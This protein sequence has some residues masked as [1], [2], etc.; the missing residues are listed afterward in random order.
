MTTPRNALRPL[1][2]RLGAGRPAR[3]RAFNGSSAPSAKATRGIPQGPTTAAI[4][5]TRNNN[6]RSNHATAGKQERKGNH[7]ALL[8]SLILTP[9][10]ILITLS[11]GVTTASAN[12]TRKFE[13]QITSVA[14]PGGVATDSANDLWVGD[15]APAF[16]V[17]EFE[18]ASA[19]NKPV[20]LAKPFTVGVDP[21]SIAIESATT[22]NGDVYV[23]NPESVG[24]E[25]FT[26]NGE[27]V[28]SWSGFEYASV[29]V[30]NS[31]EGDIA[32]PSHCV[33]AA[34]F[35]YATDRTS[36]EKLSSTGKEEAFSGSA[37]YIAAG[38]ITGRPAGLGCGEQFVLGLAE[39][40]GVA[41]DGDGDIF[42]AVPQCAEV[43][44]YLASG[45]Y[46][47]AFDLAGP[48]VQRV[49]ADGDI[50]KPEAVAVDPASNHLLVSV[51]AEAGAC[52]AIDEFD[53]ET[54][55]FVT[56]IAETGKSGVILHPDAIASDAQGDLYLTDV[57]RHAVDVWGPGGYFP[58]V[59]VGA[60][61]ERTATSA[62]LNGSVN[63][64]QSGNPTPAP[65][66]A[67]SFEYVTEAVFVKEGFAHAARATCEPAEI[68]AGLDEPHP[69][70]AT[71]EHL[72]AGTTYYYRLSATTEP[73][74]NGGT[75]DS[76]ALAFTAPGKPRVESS[77][78]ENISSTFAELHAQIDPLGAGTSYF[79]EYGP[80]T[81]YGHDAPL[82]TEA[83]PD[84][85]SIGSGGPTGSASD[86]VVQ[87]IGGLTPGTAY[88]FRVVATNEC[89]AGKQCVT[90][91]ADQT[92]ATLPR[93]T[94]GLPDN[95]SYELVTPADKEGGSDMFAE[96]IGLNGII[97]NNT[98]VGVPAGSGGGF[99]LE[100]K[101][102]FGAFPFAAPQQAYTFTREPAR[103][104]WSTT[105]LASPALGTQSFSS[106]ELLFDPF[107]FSRVALTDG[108]GTAISEQGLVD[109]SLLGPP[110]G[111]YSTLHKDPAI[112]NTTESLNSTQV[113][114]GSRDL[115]HLVLS[116]PSTSLCPEAEAVKHGR[117]LCE[118]AGG[119]LKLVNVSPSG[120][121]PASECGA[122]LGAGGPEAGQLHGA[123]SA[124]GSRVFFTAPDWQATYIGLGGT[125]VE[126]KQGCW[127][128][129]GE[130]HGAAPKNA[131]Q[132][133]ARVDA[134]STLEV[135]APE[136]GVEESGHAPVRYPATYVGASEDG[137]KVF[138]LTQTWMTQN[139]PAGH[140]EELYEC[141]IVQEGEAPAACRLSRLSTPIGAGG[142]QDPVAGSSAWS[143]PAVSEDGSSVYFTA[144]AKLAAGATAQTPVTTETDSPI[145]LYRYDT[146]TG[147]TSYIT[148]VDTLDDRKSCGF[149]LGPGSCTE[150][151]WYTT[152]DGSFLLFGSSWPGE[153]G[154]NAVAGGCA[155][156]GLPFTQA[157]KDGRCSELYRYDAGA[158]ER[159]EQAVVCVSCGSPSADAAGNA[160]FARSA[161]HG[162]AAGAVPAIS[163]NG[164][165]VFFDSQA[166]LVPEAKNET[167]DTYE[168]HEDEKTGAR[169]VSLI[170]SGSDPAPTFFLGYSPYEYETPTG[171]DVC[172]RNTEREPEPGHHCEVVEGGNV[173][174]G[175]HAKL[176]PQDTNS[177]GNIFDA[178]VCEPE[179]PC[180]QP[181][182]G[183]TAQ[184]P[185]SE[186]QKP[187]PA[188]PDPVATLLAPPAPAGLVAP[189]PPAKTAAQ[190][191][192]EGLAK[193]L[194]V[195]KRDKSAKKRKTCEASAQKKYGATKKATKAKAKKSAHINRRAPR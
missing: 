160:E 185:G 182:L 128:P 64:A 131:P 143:V 122:S 175:T 189:P 31:P 3:V 9:L 146:E 17:D 45:K 133:Y 155:E 111:P 71:V 127:N 54:G 10:L 191:K 112:H 47:G 132:L 156:E 52:G 174:I 82:L 142:A 24:L 88:Y 119:E 116:S 107:D 184:C 90:G 61:S 1:L 188:P 123:V 76:E 62:V 180:I 183:E 153:H 101:S 144:F 49:C 30:D 124:D 95:R 187:P 106:R 87:R 147:V 59:T 86:G 163:E 16:A 171:K 26:P 38:R 40:R 149:Y 158:A 2:H 50:G 117:V 48:Q 13:R 168:W 39:P 145:N 114:G 74:H 162:A 80:T 141:E 126:G 67:C 78:A 22:G 115:E 165:Y 167:L 8:R 73:A 57:E 12:F 157:A 154:E 104:T 173:F 109:T 79:F 169:S 56:Q 108:L 72:T 11:F 186:C 21:G 20:S 159:G 14:N 96:S 102:S 181:P 161:P 53:I 44:E 19:G 7:L 152:P 63:P 81:A 195:C 33:L 68:H 28:E 75:A 5:F 66:T 99:L 69:V 193:A 121:A 176:V 151:D 92:F 70:K 32:D 23:G 150:R 85:A 140:D 164:E 178:R 6:L 93:A 25:V 120:E 179:S 91:G 190:I 37:S 192:A 129:E 130:A 15:L 34:C 46:V 170:G 177:V 118:S 43:F 42:L 98:D 84:G 60:T 58:T 51:Y 35:V 125:G 55:G 83:E 194:K 134:T 94:V 29:A 89:E 137:G 138:F 36:V 113:V 103:D 100:T 135:S 18:P 139:H 65:V 77:I 105:S 148:T 136:A 97:S 110:G 41:V 166:S 27:H 172:R 4:T